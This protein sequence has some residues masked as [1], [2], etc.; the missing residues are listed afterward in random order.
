MKKLKAGILLL[1]LMTLI[2]SWGEIPN[3]DPK[4][5]FSEVTRNKKPN[6]LSKKEKKKGWL[7]LFDGKSTDG[8]HGYNM[9]EFPDCWKIE[10][11]CLTM[12]SKG[13]HEDQDI[14]TNKK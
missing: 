6:T 8:W 9:K 3:N 4:S 1:V 10:D 13:G 5:L 12:N 14:I 7:L 2:I 11:S